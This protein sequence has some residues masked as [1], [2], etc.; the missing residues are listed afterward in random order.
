MG[1]TVINKLTGIKFKIW[2]VTFF[3]SYLP[4]KNFGM[5]FR[6]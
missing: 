2:R 1:K 4:L 5:D 3:K 6:F